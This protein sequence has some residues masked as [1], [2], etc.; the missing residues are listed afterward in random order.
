MED[1]SS[2]GQLVTLGLV[3][4]SIG[5]MAKRLALFDMEASITKALMCS[6]ILIQG[7]A[8]SSNQFSTIIVTSTVDSEE[9]D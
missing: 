2:T 1:F 6:V 4:S 8:I 3:D 5:A 7:H 9:C